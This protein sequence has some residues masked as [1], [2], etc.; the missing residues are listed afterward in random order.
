[1]NQY[2]AQ[3]VLEEV[4]TSLTTLPTK[5][6]W[7]KALSATGAD[8]CFLVAPSSLSV[9]VGTLTQVLDTISIWRYTK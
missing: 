1:V 7:D 5:E 3:P 8:Q 2:F 4:Y 9:G 6:A